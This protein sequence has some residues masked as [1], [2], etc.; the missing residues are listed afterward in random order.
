MALHT[1]CRAWPLS[2]TCL[3]HLVSPKSFLILAAISRRSLSSFSVL[4]FLVGSRLSIRFV[5]SSSFHGL[6]QCDLP[7][8]RRVIRPF[9]FLRNHKNNIGHRRWCSGS[10]PRWVSLFPN[11]FDLPSPTWHLPCVTQYSIISNEWGSPQSLINYNGVG[12]VEGRLFG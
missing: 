4:C 7:P 2:T 5:W 10:L 8:I 1:P 6:L 3:H 11:G 9:I 12:G